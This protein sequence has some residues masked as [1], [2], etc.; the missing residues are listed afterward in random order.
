MAATTA[1]RAANEARWPRVAPTARSEDSSGAHGSTSLAR[2]CTPS[3]SA[4]SPTAAP[5]SPRLT[6]SGR[7]ARCTLAE[8]SSTRLMIGGISR[9]AGS[10]ERAETKSSMPAAPSS[11]RIPCQ[12]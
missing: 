2:A 12:E 10:V 11:S 1:S 9:V 8:V 6:A 3:T 4:A 7:M 5:K